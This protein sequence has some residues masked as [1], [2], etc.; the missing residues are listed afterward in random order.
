MIP[1]RGVES[2]REHSFPILFQSFLPL[3]VRE[4][5]GFP[6]FFE[7]MRRE[8]FLLRRELTRVVE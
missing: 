7:R 3:L 4:R 2:E 1:E 5:Q 6:I 8:K